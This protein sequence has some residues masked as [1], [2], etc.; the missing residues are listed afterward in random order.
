LVDEGI[1]RTVARVGNDL[2]KSGKLALTDR[3]LRIHFVS[4]DTQSRLAVERF[5]DY[6]CSEVLAESLRTGTFDDYK[7]RQKAEAEID[8]RIKVNLIGDDEVDMQLI[9]EVQHKR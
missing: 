5:R 8:V 7:E 2:R 9:F 4:D 6:I 1:A 3:L